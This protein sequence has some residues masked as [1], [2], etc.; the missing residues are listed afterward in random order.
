[1]CDIIL[2]IIGFND[3]RRSFEIGRKIIDLDPP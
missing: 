3:L 1:M 2:A